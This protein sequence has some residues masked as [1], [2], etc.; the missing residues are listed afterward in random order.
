MDSPSCLLHGSQ[1]QPCTQRPNLPFSRS[2]ITRSFLRIEGLCFDCFRD[3]KW[4]QVQSAAQVNASPMLPGEEG[5]PLTTAM[6][7]AADPSQR[8]QI[9]GERLFPQV[10]RMQPELAGK[11]TGQSPTQLVP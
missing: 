4:V 8:K 9:L 2:Q 1:N 11:I 3:G 7:A 10:N 6:L 5:P